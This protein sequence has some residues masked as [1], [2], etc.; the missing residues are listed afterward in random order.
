MVATVLWMMSS[1]LDSD[2]EGA[3]DSASNHDTVEHG[4]VVALEEKEGPGIHVGNP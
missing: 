2:T 1:P 3:S 4:V